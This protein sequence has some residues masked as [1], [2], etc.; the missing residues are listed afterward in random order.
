MLAIPAK[1]GS[2]AY[3]HELS[4]FHIG[5]ARRES[6]TVLSKVT[7]LDIHRQDHMASTL[8]L[9]STDE[10]FSRHRMSKWRHKMYR[11]K[12]AK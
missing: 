5:S 9:T 6:G 7:K 8:A 10:I 12:E 3:L 1:A 11:E 4:T 2:Y